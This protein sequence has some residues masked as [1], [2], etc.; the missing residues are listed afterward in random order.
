LN[1][2]KIE[3]DQDKI[4]ILKCV[5]RYEIK[6]KEDVKK[7]EKEYIN[8]AAIKYIIKELKNTNARGIDGMN[9]NMVK[10][11]NSELIQYKISLLIN[12]ILYTGYTPKNLNRTIIL[13]I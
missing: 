11:V 3:N 6:A 8:R 4:E 12:A 2:E 7:D 10:R 1:N 13:P 5:N 9:N